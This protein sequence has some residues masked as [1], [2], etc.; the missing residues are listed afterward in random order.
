MAAVEVPFL[1]LEQ[2]FLR[3]HVWCKVDGVKITIIHYSYFYV[4]SRSLPN[5]LTETLFQKYIVNS[6][7]KLKI[8]APFS[9]CYE[10]LVYKFWCRNVGLGVK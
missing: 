7:K 5:V 9:V 10:D 6:M 2:F 3:S 4:N 1:I 8:F